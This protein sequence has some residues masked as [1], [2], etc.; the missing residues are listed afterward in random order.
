MNNPADRE[1]KSLL[2]FPLP[3]AGAIYNDLSATLNGEDILP[4]M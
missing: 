1:L 2:K 4:R 3:A